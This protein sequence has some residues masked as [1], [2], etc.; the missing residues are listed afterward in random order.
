[1]SE[2]TRI[3][4]GGKKEYETTEHYLDRQLRTF[5]CDSLSNWIGQINRFWEND[6]VTV[7]DKDNHDIIK[8]SLLRFFSRGKIILELHSRLESSTQYGLWIGTNNF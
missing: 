1:M 4:A 7:I 2:E 8:G 5:E 6:F 3:L